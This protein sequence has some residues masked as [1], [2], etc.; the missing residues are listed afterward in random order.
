MTRLLMSVDA[1]G[2]VWTYALDLSRALVPLG[3]TTTLALLGPAASPDQRA[4]AA[5]IHGLNLIETGEPLDWLADGEVQLIGAAV[6]LAD[7]ALRLR[8]DIVQLNSPALAALARF[9]PPVLGVAHSCLATW[10]GAVQSGTMPPDFAWRASLL[11]RGY[12]ACDALV[13]PTAA[14]ATATEAT[15]GIGPTVIL[16]GAPP[17]D[18]ADLA[19]SREVLTAG[20]LWDIGKNIATLDRAAGRLDAPVIAAGVTADPAG[21]EV[22]LQH[23]IPL[24]LLPTD[25]LHISMSR[26]QVFAS[27]AVYEPFGLTV[28]EAARAGCALVLS[29]I[30]SFRELW[31]GVAI[32]VPPHDDA[33]A[34]TALQTLLDDAGRARRAGRAARSRAARYTAAAMAQKMFALYQTLG[35]RRAAA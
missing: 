17:A 10:W 35:A 28:L 34:A 22:R 26:V 16:N 1:V 25:A 31:E 19:R 15:Y 8:A 13:A 14:F 3:V 11:A 30:P 7:L 21:H 2:G 5:G 33:A 23:I 12:A 29:D 27:L 6:K 9:R 24:G 4:A 18:A 32:F 20:R